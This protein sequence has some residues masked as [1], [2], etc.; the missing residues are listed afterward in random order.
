MI[1]ELLGWFRRDAEAPTPE[2]RAHEP[3]K[4]PFDQVMLDLETYGTKPGCVVLSICAATFN[5]RGDVDAVFSKN[6]EYDTQVDMGLFADPETVAWWEA[7]DIEAVEATFNNQ[8][9]TRRVLFDFT[10]WWEMHVAADARVWAVGQDFDG[11]ILTRCMEMMGVRDKPLWPF[12]ALRDVRSACDI[13]GIDRS[14]RSTALVK[15]SAHAD[16][17]HQIKC[18][19]AAKRELASNGL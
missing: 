19:V 11:P 6:L 16:V 18:V 3:L 9:P 14:R 15:H 5:W 17:L 13:A 10:T 12:W 4:F 2:P 8:E 1:H 7:Q